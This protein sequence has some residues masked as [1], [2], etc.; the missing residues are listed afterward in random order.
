MDIILI[1]L[2]IIAVLYI[3]QQKKT[4]AASEAT[5]EKPVKERVY[6]YARKMLLT[7]AEYSFYKILKEICDQN[8]ILICPKVRMEDFLEVTD[9][10][11]YMKYRGYIKS[12]HIDFML[13][14]SDL[15]IIA[16]LE[17]DDNSHKKSNVQEKDDFKN[18]VFKT[19]NIPL[20]RV[21]MSDGSYKDRLEKIMLELIKPEV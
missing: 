14:D 13:C 21:K 2:L 20:Y 9:K 5:T 12:R 15:R 1:I 16:G 7:K 19:V 6:P 18:N 17:L 3:V 8:K 11:N 10:K 4:Q